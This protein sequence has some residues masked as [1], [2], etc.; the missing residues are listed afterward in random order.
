MLRPSDP[1]IDFDFA[2]C[3]YEFRSNDLYDGFRVITLGHA[4]NGTE[5][6]PAVV[7]DMSHEMDPII[8]SCI[9]RHMS[10][11][12]GRDVFEMMREPSGISSLGMKLLP[13]AFWLKLM[14]RAVPALIHA[15]AAALYAVAVRRLYG[16]VALLVSMPAMFGR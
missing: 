8:I 12:S 14:R 5:F 11:V 4:D 16:R 1:F 3:L 10:D 7:T 13:F 6:R 2:G 9:E 15:F